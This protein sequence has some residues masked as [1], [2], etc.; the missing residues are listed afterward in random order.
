MIINHFILIF[1]DEVILLVGTTESTNEE[2]LVWKLS[3]DG[4]SNFLLAG[5]RADKC[6]NYKL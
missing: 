2:Y 6:K 1:L 4:A 3:F 5:I